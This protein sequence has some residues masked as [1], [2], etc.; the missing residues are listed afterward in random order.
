MKYQVGYSESQIRNI[1]VE[2]DS[3]EEAER[4]VMDGDVDY[5]ESVEVDATVVSVNSVEEM[6]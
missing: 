4:M 6:R 5:S 1:T 2:A 3:P